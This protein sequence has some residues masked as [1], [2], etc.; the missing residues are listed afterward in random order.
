[1]TLLDRPKQG[2]LVFDEFFSMR[3]LS[4]CCVARIVH[5]CGHDCVPWDMMVQQCANRLSKKGE[6]L[7]DVRN[8]LQKGVC[9]FDFVCLGCRV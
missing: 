5:F 3:S 6:S 9:D 1:M 4:L 7:K 2:R 8:S